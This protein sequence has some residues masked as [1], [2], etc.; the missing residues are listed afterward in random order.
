M[1]WYKKAQLEFPQM[2]EQ[3]QKDIIYED[4]LWAADRIIAREEIFTEQDFEK[5]LDTY[6]GENQY[7]SKA[8][9]RTKSVSKAKKRSIILDLFGKGLS[10][11]KINEQ[12][13]FGNKEIK[14]II[15]KE[16]NIPKIKKDVENIIKGPDKQKALSNVSISRELNVPLLIVVRIVKKMNIN[17]DVL[18]TERK[19]RLALKVIEIVDKLIKRGEKYSI[20]IIRKVFK[21]EMGF[22]IGE[23][24]VSTG[25]AT[26]NRYQSS[27][28]PIEPMVKA[29]ERLVFEKTYPSI[30]I[31]EYLLRHPGREGSLFINNIID[32]FILE[33]GHNFKNYNTSQPQ[34]KV[35]MKEDIIKKLQLRDLFDSYKNLKTVE[36]RRKNQQ[37]KDFKFDMTPNNPTYYTTER[38]VENEMPNL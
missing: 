20:A 21:N 18:R 13:G 14:D 7:L 9:Q 3:P 24:A 34:E 35:R 23:N 6:Y 30:S 32:N 25:L 4:I 11:K 26:H 19:E 33:Y 36:D 1:N 15:D 27:R 37:R 16:L 17:Y 2:Q 38:L 5:A 29:I 12:T 31:Y 22:T 8:A 28:D 10:P